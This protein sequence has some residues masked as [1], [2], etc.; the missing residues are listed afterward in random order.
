M[1]GTNWTARKVSIVGA[2]HVGATFAYALAQSGVADD[3]ALVD[4]N[5][6]LA[7]GQVL[8]LSHGRFFFPRSPSTSVGRTTMPTLT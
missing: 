4:L 5:E 2:G 8:D 1:N 7:S 6:E 3:I